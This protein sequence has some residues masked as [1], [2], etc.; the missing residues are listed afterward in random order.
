M[1][2]DGGVSHVKLKLKELA[3]YFEGKADR[4]TKRHFLIELAR[5]AFSERAGVT[6]GAAYRGGSNRV[7]GEVRHEFHFLEMTQ[8]GVP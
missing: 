5:R 7:G 4:H 8:L 3:Y 2:C 1:R 6:R